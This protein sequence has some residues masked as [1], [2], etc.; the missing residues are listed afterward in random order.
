MRFI[1]ASIATLMRWLSSSLAARRSS[2]VFIEAVRSNASTTSTV[3]LPQ[4]VCVLPC[5]LPGPA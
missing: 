3:S 2:L 5:L 1:A 4:S